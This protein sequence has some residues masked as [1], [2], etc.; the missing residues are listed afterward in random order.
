MYLVAINFLLFCCDGPIVLSNTVAMY[1]DKYAIPS[2]YP[3]YP[4]Y[5]LYMES[6]EA[7][8]KNK[9]F[10]NGIT[11]SILGMGQQQGAGK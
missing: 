7:H 11:I 1:L 5:M 3:M 8:G 2:L 4:M 6:N 9:Q 10:G